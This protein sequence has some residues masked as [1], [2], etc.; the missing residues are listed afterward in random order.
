VLAALTDGGP[1]ALVALAAQDGFEPQ[2]TYSSACD[3]CT[4][5][6]FFL[7]SRGGFAELGPRGFYAPRSAAY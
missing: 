7:A 1:A 4:H 5:V 2:A 6:R 3:L